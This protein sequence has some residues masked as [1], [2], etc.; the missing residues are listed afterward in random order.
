MEGRKALLCAPSQNDHAPASSQSFTDDWSEIDETTMWNGQWDFGQLNNSDFTNFDQ[1]LENFVRQHGMAESSGSSSVRTVADDQG[2][3]FEP[4]NDAWMSGV[5]QAGAMH[6]VMQHH[7]NGFGQTVSHQHYD[8]DP[9]IDPT[10]SEY[11]HAHPKSSSANVGKDYDNP[12]ADFDMDCMQFHVLPQE[13]VQS[14]LETADDH[15]PLT[16]PQGEDSPHTAIIHSELNEMDGL[17][18][19]GALAAAA[20]ALSHSPIRTDAP[21]DADRASSKKR[22]RTTADPAMTA[23]ISVIDIGPQKPLPKLSSSLPV[24]G[25]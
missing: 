17:T 2:M 16:S 5:Q 15:I 14:N 23:S 3:T 19:L 18:R 20:S 6:P 4:L 22:K 25:E 1:A 10:L 11:A 12:T 7:D 8:V 9:S 21:A 13:Q 24:A